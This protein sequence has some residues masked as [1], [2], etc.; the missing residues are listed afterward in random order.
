MPPQKETVPQILRSRS[1]R[2]RPHRERRHLHS[3]DST[4]KFFLVHC[5]ILVLV[6]GIRY[7]VIA[8]LDSRPNWGRYTDVKC[9]QAPVS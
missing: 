3:G 8:I 4:R 5:V 2:H 7:L 6:H 9:R 1:S